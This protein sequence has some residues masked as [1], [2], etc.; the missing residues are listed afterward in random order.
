MHNKSVPCN[1]CAMMG[2][3]LTERYAGNPYFSV[4]MQ[5][6]PTNSNTVIGVVRETG[7]TQSL[8][9]ADVNAVEAWATP[10]LICV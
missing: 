5:N 6:D 2:G 1:H 9:F 7:E 8:P 10:R 3:M 4:V